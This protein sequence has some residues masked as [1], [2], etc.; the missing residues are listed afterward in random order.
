MTEEQCCRRPLLSSLWD[1]AKRVIADPIPV[2][3]AIAEARMSQCKN[4]DKFKDGKCEEC[5]CIM[6]IKVK[7]A[8]MECPIGRWGKV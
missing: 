5:G 7:F 4:C 3:N 8:E 6:K 2:S 1:S